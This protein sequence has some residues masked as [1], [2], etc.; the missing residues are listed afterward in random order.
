MPAVP[1]A[2]TFA[3]SVPLPSSSLNQLRDMLNFLASPPI[4]ELRQIVV[5]TL[6]TGVGAAVTFTSEGVD[7]DVDGTGGHSTSSNTSRYT[8]RYPGW[9]QVSGVVAFAGNV[10]GRRICWWTING[11]SANATQLGF[12]PIATGDQEIPA[13]TAHVYL[14]AG[15]YLELIAYQES[16]GNLDTLVAGSNNVAS[17]AASVRWVKN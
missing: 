9:Y 11:V 6:T 12:G 1:T 17:S 13:R 5:Q 15:D 8:A 2:P 14:A 7:T 4:A 3:D 10:T 16:G